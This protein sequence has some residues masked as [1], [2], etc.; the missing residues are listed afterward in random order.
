MHTEQVHNICTQPKEVFTKVYRAWAAPPSQSSLCGVGMGDRQGSRQGGFSGNSK[1][2]S[3]PAIL[4]KMALLEASD[5]SK[6]LIFTTDAPRALICFLDIA[7]SGEKGVYIYWVPTSVSHTPRWYISFTTNLR[8]GSTIWH[9]TFVD[10][11]LCAKLSDRQASYF[12]SIFTAILEEDITLHFVPRRK[13]SFGVAEWLWEVPWL[14][15]G[16]AEIEDKF[17]VT[18][19]P[20]TRTRLIKLKKLQTPNSIDTCVLLCMPLPDSLS[21]HLDEIV[22][23]FPIC[24]KLSLFRVL[25]VHCLLLHWISLSFF[26]F[27]SQMCIL[28]FILS[29]PRWVTA[30]SISG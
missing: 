16:K 27:H 20:K 5:S 18:Q 1:G 7:S 2:P 26:L 15:I 19:R 24:H 28:R 3:S 22:Y 13:W 23:D 30:G 29:K 11:V 25:N 9:F 21:G 4:S 6:G 14:G 8:V 12:I 10:S 17:S